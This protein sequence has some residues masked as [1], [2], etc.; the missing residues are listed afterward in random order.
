MT[1]I[2]LIVCAFLVMNIVSA[3]VGTVDVKQLA[4][5]W[6]PDTRNG[7]ENTAK[8]IDITAVGTENKQFTFQEVGGIKGEID[9]RGP[10]SSNNVSTQAQTDV[11][12]REF[13]SEWLKYVSQVADFSLS[14]TG[15]NGKTTRYNIKLTK[16]N[17]LIYE[18]SFTCEFDL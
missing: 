4:G 17:K 12:E 14:Y 11:S 6:R 2:G 7:R 10:L 1:N 15:E 8:E 16:R 13:L 9:L 3:V 5:H 18:R